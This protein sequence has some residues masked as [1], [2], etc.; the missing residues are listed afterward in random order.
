MTDD[1]SNFPVFV[2]PVDIHFIVSK[3]ETHKQVITVY[4]PYDFTIRYRVLS[5]APKKYKVMEPTGHIRSKCYM[6]MYGEKCLPDADQNFSIVRH[7]SPSIQEVT[8]ADLLRLEIFRDSDTKPCGRKDISLNVLAADI[9]RHADQEQF[10]SFPSTSSRG[11]TRPSQRHVTFAG[12]AAQP[13]PPNHQQAASFYW[14]VMIGF[15]VC[16]TAIMLPTQGD[17]GAQKSIFPA[18]LHPTQNLQLA[19]AYVLGLIT[20]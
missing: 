10:Q 14:L 20:V 6:D 16:I 1:G 19:A 5:N 7:L 8:S 13:Q 11:S 17:K 3:P 12:V 2:S 18:Y 9:T 4:N 15:F